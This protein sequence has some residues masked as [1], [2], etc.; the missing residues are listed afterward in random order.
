[1]AAFA[2]KKP[3][4]RSP[5]RSKPLRNPGESTDRRLVDL[6]FDELL[7]W[8]V[9]A[10]FLVAL[11]VMEWIRWSTKSPPSPRTY[12]VLAAF[13]VIAAAWKLVRA[14]AEA[15]NLKLGRDGEKA[16]G[17]S[18]ERLRERN[19]RVFHDVPGS[20][21]NIDHVVIDV[22]GVYV[23]ETK[24]WS[25]PARGDAV[26]IYDGE[27]VSKGGYAPDRDPIRQ[28]RALSGWL[29]DLLEESAGTRFPVRPVVLYPEWYIQ[30]TTHARSSDVWVLNPKALPAFIANSAVK[31]KADEV[32]LCAFHLSRYISTASP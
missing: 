5:L 29:A 31:L 4:S 24:T 13:A 21:F 2:G 32:T 26:L 6:C 25:K 19:A 1:M 11:A 14:R 10:A 17:Q 12:T 22:T 28:V 16:V 27:T 30:R 7:P 8:L 9:G 18:L 3:K 15:R 23:I 20:G